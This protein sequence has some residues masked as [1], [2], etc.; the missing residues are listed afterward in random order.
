[1]IGII[2][3]RTRHAWAWA[4]E[5][6]S[7]IVLLCA[8]VIA[9]GV[10]GFAEIADEV[11][12]GDTQRFDEW[13]IQSLRRADDPAMPIGPT[14]LHEVGRDATALG[15]VFVLT[16]MTFAV[17]G[18]L[19]IVRKFH[20][21]WLVLG[22]TFGGLVLSTILKNMFNRERPSVVPHLS[23]VHTS[24]FPSGHSMLS[25]VV[26]L[27]LGVMLSRLVPNRA[28]KIYFLVLAML[29]SF[30][31]GISRVYMGVHYPTDVLAGWTA[32]CVWA[33]LCYVVARQLQKRGKVEKDTE[34]PGGIQAAR[35]TQGQG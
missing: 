8:L 5:H 3:S 25:A 35:A 13:A 31:I 4:R 14:W 34:E 19:V 11:L 10:W 15:G 6:V 7:L 22:A 30:I 21:M 23:I 16:L 33:T 24:S 12:E 2:D 9:G 18:Y 1:M 20:A 32:G 26:Y 27:T 29:L 17:A 28:A